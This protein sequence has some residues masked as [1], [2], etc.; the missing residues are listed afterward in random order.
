MADTVYV[1]DTVYLDCPSVAARTGSG[2][3]VATVTAPDG[4][5]GYLIATV[6]PGAGGWMVP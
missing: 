5:P 3:V 1:A 6:L 2:V 4:L